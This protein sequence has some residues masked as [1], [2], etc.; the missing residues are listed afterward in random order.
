[1]DGSGA[2]PRRATTGDAGTVTELLVGAFHEDP[3]WAWPFP[4]ADARREQ[5]RALFR[6]W[7]DGALHYPHS[8]LAA[9][10]AATALWIPPGGRDL[11]EAE[12]QALEALLATLPDGVADRLRPALELFDSTHPRDVPHFYL[13]MLATDP[14][15][16]GR[17]IGLSLLAANLRLVDTEGAPA[18]LEASNPANVPLYERYGFRAVGSFT[19]PDGGPEV[20][21]MWRDPSGRG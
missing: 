3:T 2:V 17:G 1:M 9:D 11:G 4:D 10:D 20:V 13:G 15:R 6:I 7:V 19:L 18:Y 5:Q 16:R 21:R 14:R 8:W 12:E